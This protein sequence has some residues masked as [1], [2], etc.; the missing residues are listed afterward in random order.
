MSPL[1]IIFIIY[2]LSFTGKITLYFYDPD[3]DLFSEPEMDPAQLKNKLFKWLMFPRINW[4]DTLPNL[5]NPL[6]FL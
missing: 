5:K 3:L 2:Y 1:V 6:Y 4:R